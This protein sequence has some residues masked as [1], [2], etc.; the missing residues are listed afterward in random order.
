MMTTQ[1][2]YAVDATVIT[3][4]RET[5]QSLQIE[6]TPAADVA[7]KPGV[8]SQ[9]QTVVPADV[10][11]GLPPLKFPQ[12]IK[13]P[14]NILTAPYPTTPGQLDIHK[15]KIGEVSV[16]LDGKVTF[17]GQPLYNQDADAIKK[18]CQKIMAKDR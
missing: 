17:N 12:E 18:A 10:E 4:N 7:Y 2:V 6:A 8:D 14:I 16:S 1:M 15:G 5:C 3:L 11:N 13:I 9:G